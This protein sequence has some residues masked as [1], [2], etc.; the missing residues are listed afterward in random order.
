MDVGNYTIS[1]H[2]LERILDMNIPG[3]EVKQCLE[4][5]LRIADS[6]RGDGRTLYY[7]KRITC[8]VQN[9]NLSVVTVLWK[10]LHD[11]NVDLSTGEY[12]DRRKRQ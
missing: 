9:H 10:T 2:A 6:N 11:W 12:S 1:R 5:P 7:G 3:E 4:F 8:V